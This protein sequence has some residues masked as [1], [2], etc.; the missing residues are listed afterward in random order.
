MELIT[1]DLLNKFSK[2]AHFCT[3]RQGG[4]SVG[5]YASMNMS[6]FSGDNVEHQSENLNLLKKKLNSTD[7][8]IPF[9]THG[10]EIGIINE[11]FIQKNFAER[12]DLLN[13][14]D[15][16]ITKEPN[17][18]IGVTTADCV[19]LIFY[20]PQLEV[21]A[22]AHAGWRGTCGRIAEKVVKRMQEE[23]GTH[24]QHINV[25]IGPSISGTVYNVGNELIDNFSSAGFPVAEIFNTNNELIYLDLWKANQWLLESMGVPA[26][27]IQISE[28]C[29]Y[30]QHE[31]FF[32]ARRLGLKSGRMLSAIMLK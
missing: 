26:D 9:Q 31:K 23:F 14:V 2:I 24:P 29:T 6:P 32:S 27:H 10:T 22:V 21:I 4:V 15:A 3:T 5:N 8:I 19:P 11:D 16:L 30:T 18:C 12:A 13:G 20:D 17:V 1:F 25:V 28:I 7:L